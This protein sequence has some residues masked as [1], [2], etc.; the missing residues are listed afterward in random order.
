[1]IN[2]YYIPFLPSA[3]INYNSYLRIYQKAEYNEKEKA[4]SIIHYESV[5]SLSKLVGIPKSTLDRILQNT[6][7][8]S[9]FSVDK[10]KKEIH[11][12][13]TFTKG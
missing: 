12:N 3:G 4:F 1:M 6:K 7:Y 13:T 8:S 10:E 9:F 2:K 5:K 11:L